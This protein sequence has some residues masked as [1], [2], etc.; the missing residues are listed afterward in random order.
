MLHRKC[1]SLL[2]SDQIAHP[3]AL[4]VLI[5]AAVVLNMYFAF[6]VPF[7]VT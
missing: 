4:A 1:L 3:S 7:R 6:E 5:V 2:I